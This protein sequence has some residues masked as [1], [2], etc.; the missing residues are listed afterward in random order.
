MI[1]KMIKKLYIYIYIYIQ[2]VYKN[3]GHNLKDN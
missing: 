3:M 2:D 1:I